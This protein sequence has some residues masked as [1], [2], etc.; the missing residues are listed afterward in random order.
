[1]LPLEAS[2]VYARTDHSSGCSQ[3]AVA[4]QPTVEVFVNRATKLTFGAEVSAVTMP[5]L[6]SMLV[7][8]SPQFWSS[9]VYEFASLQKTYRIRSDQ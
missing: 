5:Q 6:A 8:R 7:L 2:S 9:L 4:V 1:M 3:L